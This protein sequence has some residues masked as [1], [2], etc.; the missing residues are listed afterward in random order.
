MTAQFWP[1]P[2]IPLETILLFDASFVKNVCN[3]LLVTDFIIVAN[4]LFDRFQVIS[5]LGFTATMYQ[6]EKSIEHLEYRESG[7]SLT[8]LD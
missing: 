8:K 1:G 6:K 2:F 5:I 7:R 3:H 4:N